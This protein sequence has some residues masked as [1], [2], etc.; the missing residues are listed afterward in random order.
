MSWHQRLSNLFRRDRVWHDIDRELSF[1]LHERVDELKASGMP[2]DEA[3]RL[4]QQQLG[5][6]RLHLEDALE[7]DIAAWLE[8]V[9]EDLRYALR[10][11]SRNASLSGA[12]VATLTLGIGL[13]ASI[14][15]LIDGFAFRPLVEKDPRSFV[16]ILASYS[17]PDSNGVRHTAAAEPLEWSD[18]LALRET[19]RSVHDFAAWQQVQ[20]PLELRDTASVRAFLVTC[21]FFG[22]HNVDHAEL[23]RLFE[24]GDCTQGPPTIVLTHELW[25]E[26]FGSDPQIVGKA[27]HY[28]GRP[29]TVIGV[30][31]LTAFAG[32]LE[33]VRSWIPHTAAPQLGI[34]GRFTK[35]L[36]VAARLNPGVSR[37]AVAS[38]LTMIARQ[39][40]QLHPNRQTQIL[41][42]DGSRF[43]DPQTSAR[44]FFVILFIMGILL[45]V[46]LMACAN[47]ATLLLSRAAGRHREIA[48]RMALGAGS[49]RLVRMLLTENAVLAAIAGAASLYVVYHVPGLLFSYVS[50]GKTFPFDL[51]WRVVAYLAAVTGV[52]AVLSGL[53]PA[54]EALNVHIAESLKGGLGWSR[55]RTG[56]MPTGPRLRGFLVAGQVSLSLVLLIGAGICIAAYGRATLG[57]LGFDT[58][59]VVGTVVRLNGPAPKSWSAFNRNLVDSI[60]ALPGVEAAASALSRPVFG[61]AYTFVHAPGEPPVEVQYNAVS[62]DYFATVKL[63]IERGRWLRAGDPAPGHGAAPV[64][65]SR[66]LARQFWPAEDALG[67][68]LRT[69]AGGILEVVGLAPDTSVHNFGG[70]DKP[71]FYQIW[72]PDSALYVPIVRFRGD[73]AAMSGAVRAALQRALPDAAVGAQVIQS[74][75]DQALSPFRSLAVLITMLGAIA[76][77]LALIGIYGVVS[78]A[79]KQRTQEV[80]IRI[81]LGAQKPDIFRTI[82]VDGLRPIG[83]G[84]LVGM[85][86]V[87]AVSRMVSVMLRSSEF[88]IN[89]GDSEAYAVVCIILTASAVAAM[90]GPALR[91]AACNPIDV[92]RQE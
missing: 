63:P 41:T 7:I 42:T 64:V 67:K 61:L 39:Q 65:I 3:L 28:N 2:E 30:A 53:A 54:S 48:V 87:L 36:Q 8:S 23:G 31:R 55:S 85:A 92:L 6:A 37:S 70:V 75:L 45:I 59:H 34:G 13:N 72:D 32:A 88:H 40:D 5:A 9:V 68:T 4:A 1:H 80:G 43:A 33:N 81:A 46:V 44:F 60:R 52:A 38:E 84:L 56:A 11:L 62:P 16:W 71:T 35:V 73:G 91:A 24:P 66:E 51:N 10:N 18:Y 78:F 26:R 82:L 47:V 27:I 25:Q 29:V 12:V 74:E 77:A 58:R 57:D 22:L 20:A 14:F 15:T 19:A 50:V 79:V 69:A 49:G 76:L 89:T 90:I 17:A 86:L 21:N 83:V